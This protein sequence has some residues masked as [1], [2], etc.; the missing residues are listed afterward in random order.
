MTATEFGLVVALAVAVVIAVI[1]AAALLR[2]RSPQDAVARAIQA[3]ADVGGLRTQVANLAAHQT[4]VQ[5]SLTGVQDVMP[6]AVPHE[7]S[8]G[9]R[10]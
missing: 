9:N 7:S 3:T 5:Q 8:L 6:G 4:T 2:S 10:L 1:L